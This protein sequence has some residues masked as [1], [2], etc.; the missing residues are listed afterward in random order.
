MKGSVGTTTGIYHTRLPHRRRSLQ[1]M[2]RCRD[3][4]K[5]AKT[6]LSMVGH[7]EKCK[8]AGVTCRGF[9][10]SRTTFYERLK[11]HLKEGPRG[12]PGPPP[13]PKRRRASGIPWQTVQLIC[14]LKKGTSRLHQAQDSGDLERKAYPFPYRHPPSPFTWSRRKIAV[15]LKRDHGVRLSSLSVGR[16]LKRKGLYDKG[17][18]RRKSR[19][20][21]KGKPACGRR[22]G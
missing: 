1:R 2:A 16:V 15:I 5:K 6:R 22:G 12:L 9:R 20:A 4:S 18:S 19:A 8:N 3:L 10:I 7:Y 21:K 11:R 13:T 17:I 14:D